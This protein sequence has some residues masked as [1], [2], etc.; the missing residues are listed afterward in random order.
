MT[1]EFTTFVAEHERMARALARTWVRDRSAADDVAQEAFVRAWKGW[2]SLRDPAR[3]KPW[4]YA[5]VRNTAMDWLRKERRHEAEDLPDEVAAP[6]PREPGDLVDRVGA[7]VQSL[8]AEDRQIVLMR[9]VDGLSYAEIGEA[10]GMSTGSV[11]E[12]LH[13]VRARVMER[14]GLR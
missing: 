8:R 6:A 2:G 12:K 9:F 10:L 11:G 7:V 4:L 13:R 5:I 14:L 3:V 1:D